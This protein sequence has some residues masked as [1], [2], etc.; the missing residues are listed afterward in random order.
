MEK[1]PSTSRGLALGGLAGN[2][3]HGA[4][5]LQAALECDRPP[6]MIS[7][8]SGQ[9][10]WLCRYLGCLK[11]KKREGLLRDLLVEDLA[12]VSPT[13]ME[14]VDAAV[15]SVEG[16]R[17]VFRPALLEFPLNAVSNLTRAL[18]KIVTDASKDWHALFS[19]HREFARVFPSQLL[20]PLFPNEFFRD[21]SEALNGADGIGI[22]FNS[23]DVHGGEERV[24]CNERARDLLGITFG[25]RNSYRRGTVYQRITP[26][27]VREGLWIYEYGEPP[28]VGAIDGAYYRQIILSELAPV[29][30]IYV[31]RPINSRWLGSFPKS[32]VGLQDLKT[33]VSFNG[34][35]AGER[36][37]IDL[38]NRYVSKET[39]PEGK[40]YHHINVVELEIQT[41]RGY[42][43][44]A[45]ESV[46]VF[47]LAYD[48]ARSAFSHE[49]DAGP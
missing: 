2:N 41:Q 44:Y 40:E 24:Y 36:D 22:V 25:S 10:H 46:N 15:L 39:T 9:I 20:V 19:T 47:D 49:E 26:D 33:E 48:A 16:R 6:V 1:L 3:A 23:Y 32:W 17:D 45:R 12:A 28:S 13:G 37:K 34:A 30:T 31:A 43:D 4:G 11:Q 7:C 21:A 42:F 18:A 35:Y 14:S 27:A 8:T 29:H 38:V 5:V